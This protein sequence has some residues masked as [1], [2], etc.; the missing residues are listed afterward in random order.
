MSWYA[1]LPARVGGKSRLGLPGDWSSACAMDTL[2]AVL[3]AKSVKEITVL[4]DLDCT[5]PVIKDTGQGLNNEIARASS[6]LSRPLLIILGDLPAL[7]RTDLEE[8]LKNAEA[9]EKSFV[10]DLSGSGTTMIMVRDSF[11]P[12]F[13]PNSAAL[14]A[15]DG[16][17][18]IKANLS[19]RLDVDTLEDVTRAAEIGLGIETQKLFETL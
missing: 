9:Y 14:H 12:H 4:G 6:E 17:V 11:T 3:E 15:A 1:L 10:R 5:L 2:A 8:V 18:E 7:K 13:G 16:Y 19:A